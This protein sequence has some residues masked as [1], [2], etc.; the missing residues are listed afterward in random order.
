VKRDN[1][2]HTIALLVLTFI[3]LALAIRW[4]ELSEECQDK[5]G[6]LIRWSCVQEIK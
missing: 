6:V 5:G 1:V 3:C 4:Y 2:V